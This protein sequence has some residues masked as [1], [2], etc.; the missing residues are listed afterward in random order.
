MDYGKFN[1]MQT[2]GYNRFNR[3]HAILGS[4]N[5]G[6]AYPLG[7]FDVPAGATISNDLDIFVRSGALGDPSFLDCDLSV[8][9]YFVSY[10][11][12]DH[13]Y[14]YRCQAFKGTLVDQSLF[15]FE[16]GVNSHTGPWKQLKPF[17]AAGS[18][19]DHLGFGVDDSDIADDG[20]IKWPLR[21]P[22]APLIAYHMIVDRFFSNSRLQDVEQTRKALMMIFPVIQKTNVS[23]DVS[24]P[25]TDPVPST[26]GGYLSPWWL[27]LREV[28]Y[29][30]D[31]FT[32]A[33]DNYSGSVVMLPGVKEDGTID[34]DK[35]TIHNLLDNMLVQKVADMIERG[36][37]SYN[38]FMRIIYGVEPN[39]VISEY[40]IFLGGASSP[41]QV[42]TVVNQTAFP[43]S[44][45]TSPHL[46]EEAGRVN[47][48]LKGG[49]GFT[50]RFDR[51]GIYM[52]IMWIRPQ[53]YYQSGVSPIFFQ[54]S[55]GSRLIPQLADMQDAPIYTSEV[56]CTAGETLSNPLDKFVFGYKDRYQEYRTTPNRVVGEMRKQRVS[57]YMARNFEYDRISSDFISQKNLRYTPWVVT[58]DKVD[59][60]YCRIFHNFQNTV[61]LPMTSRPYV[62]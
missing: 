27:T 53:C 54:D 20:A 62:W 2:F 30:P 28:N 24:L 55:I 37:Y 56:L 7:C 10:D 36:G 45:T 51:D 60:F 29:E 39:D 26:A 18:L 23:V 48:Y 21:L 47:A 9:H 43:S 14:K 50:R 12:I 31:Y 13:F 34:I 52:P 25:T 44:S 46:G 38:D 5:A 59:H 32:T 19:L 6:K 8:G 40:P 4:Y 15:T 3:R 41:L 16:F 1:S 33:R 35:A 22:M 49:D 61:P 57:W 42:S 58:D 17:I 11:A